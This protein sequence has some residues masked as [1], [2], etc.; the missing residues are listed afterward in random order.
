MGMVAVLLASSSG[1]DRAAEAPPHDTREPFYARPPAPEVGPSSLLL[2]TDRPMPKL[3]AA[4]IEVGA[5]LGAATIWYVIATPMMQADWRYDLSW[6]TVRK[7]LT[8]EAVGFDDNPLFMNAPGHAVAGATYYLAG[9]HNDLG[10]PMSLAAAGVGTL[11]WELVTEYREIVSVND[12]IITPIGG[13]A[14]GEAM[15]QLS[16]YFRRSDPHP[17]FSRVARILAGPSSLY[18]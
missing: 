17:S 11:G 9:R 7:K 13:V 3:Q 6:S 4:G 8:G 1:A 14:I 16:D 5:I 2:P 10:G 15:F 12:L 18:P